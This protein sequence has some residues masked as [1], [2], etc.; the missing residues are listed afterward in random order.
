MIRG[1]RWRTSLHRRCSGRDRSRR[2][3]TDGKALVG[4]AG[5]VDLTMLIGWFTGVSLTLAAFDVPSDA[6]GLDQ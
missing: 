3:F 5:I 6:T 1:S 4:D 2:A